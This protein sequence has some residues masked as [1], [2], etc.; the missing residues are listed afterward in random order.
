MGGISQILAQEW[1]LLEVWPGSKSVSQPAKGISHQIMH[2]EGKSIKKRRCNET[3]SLGR[4]AL[5]LQVFMLDTQCSAKTPNNK[6]GFEH[7]QSCVLI[8]EL[9]SDQQSNGHAQKRWTA[10][11]HWSIL[12]VVLS[13]LC[14][15]YPQLNQ[16]SFCI[17]PLFL[18]V[19][20]SC[21]VCFKMY[22]S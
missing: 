10:N 11:M 15:L 8:I 21:S 14:E 17:Y 12:G 5:W 22:T 1:I 2:V 18:L 4:F 20:L 7:A 13:V 19:K 3:E 6:D 9:P 16:N